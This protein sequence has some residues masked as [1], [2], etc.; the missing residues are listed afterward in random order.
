MKLIKVLLLSLCLLALVPQQALAQESAAARRIRR[1]AAAIPNNY[2]VV[3]KDSV[4]QGRVKA[5][6]AQLAR[7][8][9]GK[10]GFTYQHA[11]RGFSVEL[12][13]AQAL[14]LSRNPQVE[15]VEEDTLVE[16]AGVQSNPTWALDRIDQRNLPLNGSYNYANSGAGVNVYIVDGGIR[17]SHQEFSGRAVYAY[18]N[19]GDGRLGADCFGHGTHVAGIIG[20]NTY[21]VAKGVKLHSVRVL[22]CSNQALASAVVAG[23]D[24]IT[25]NHTK[26]AVANLSFFTG[27]GND[28]MD[29]AVRGMIAAGVTAVVAAGN[30][31]GDASLRSPARVTEAITVAATDENDNQSPN[32]NFGAAVDIYAPGVNIVSTWHFDDASFNTRSGTSFAAPFVA[33]V[34]ARYLSDNPQASPASVS[35]AIT[36]NAT[37]GKIPNAGAGS[38]NLLLYAET[39]LWQPVT[40][41]R[42]NYALA[43]SGAT[44]LASSTFSTDYPVT[45]INNGDRLGTGWG[46]GSGWN[47]AGGGWN[48][49]TYNSYPDWVEVR[50]G[51]ART[52]GEVDLYT[53]QDNYASPSEPTAEMTFSQYGMTKFELHYWDGAVWKVLPGT[54][55]TGNNKVWRKLTFSPITTDRIRVWV[56]GAL[57]NHSRITEVEA[58]QPAETPVHANNPNNYALAANGATVLASSTFSTA[59]PVTAVNDGDRRGI[60]W[61][62]GGGWNDADYHSYPDWVEVNFGA[63]RTLGEVDVFTLQDNYESPSEPTAEM[64][65]SQYGVTNFELHYWDGAAWRVIPGTNV[66]GNDKVWRKLTF[67]PIATDRIRVWVTGALAYHSRITEVEGYQ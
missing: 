53:L 42:P 23:M 47:G 32:S 18:D 65:F 24:W 62:A 10:V 36:S 29:R 1:S 56:E 57:S 38:P 19:V 16:G 13:E 45:S 43:S 54:S 17:Y 5:F 34:A 21:G 50:F 31:T 12:S 26:P 39:E 4:P 28:S 2:I 48:D 59:F 60:N 15:Y 9:G 6:A 8:H 63:V 67:S 64:T 41:E 58:Y 37:A 44:V 40:P 27:V 33:G 35:Q 22:N 14:A 3:F 55:V 52:L 7:A 49:A 30:N 20:G 51:A 66:T 46:T 61:G 11:L 25:P